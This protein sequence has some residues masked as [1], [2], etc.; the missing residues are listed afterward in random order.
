MTT[1]TDRELYM[2][3]KTAWAEAETPSGGGE[4]AGRRA[5]F[6]AGRASRDAELA[7]VVWVQTQRLLAERLSP[8]LVAD[9]VQ[10]L[11]EPFCVGCSGA[12]FIPQGSCRVASQD[13]IDAAEM[14]R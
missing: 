11:R 1:P 3:E 5:V 4:D 2:I 6:N 7:R 10:E 13:D 14:G 12:G 8:A 9:V